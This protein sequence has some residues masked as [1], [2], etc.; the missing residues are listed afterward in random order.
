MK[1]FQPIL[2]IVLSMALLLS[3]A[4]CASDSG[5]NTPAP[6][7][8]QILN[9][10]V[11]PETICVGTAADVTFDLMDPNLDQITWTANLSTK[12]HGTLDQTQ[13]TETSGSHLQV[14]FK[15]ATSGR[16]RHTVT[17]RVTASDAG[18]LPAEPAEFDIFVFN[19]F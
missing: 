2:S 9:L 10:K 12:I 15:A 6:E 14:R 19:C 4:G 3:A 8:P 16:H 5:T 17:L 13:G 7:A 1:F 11:D 18:G